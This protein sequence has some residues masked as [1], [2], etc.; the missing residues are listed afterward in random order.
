MVFGDGV[1]HGSVKGGCR[2]FNSIVIVVVVVYGS[3]WEGRKRQSRYCRDENFTLLRFYNR[4]AVFARIQ[5]FKAQREERGWEIF[6]VA[7]R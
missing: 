1:L 3:V 5:C 6:M 2:S 4:L 7:A